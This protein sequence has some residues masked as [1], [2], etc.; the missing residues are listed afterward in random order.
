[1]N[2]TINLDRCGREAPKRAAM[3]KALDHVCS[4]TCK[5]TGYKNNYILESTKIKTYIADIFQQIKNSFCHQKKMTASHFFLENNLVLE[6]HQLLFKVRAVKAVEA[7]IHLWIHI[8][9]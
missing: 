9:D 1:M 3:S 2:I 8:Y 7:R 5:L 4:V 6:Y